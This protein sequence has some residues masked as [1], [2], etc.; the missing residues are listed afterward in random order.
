GALAWA[1]RDPEQRSLRIRLTVAGLLLWNHF[2]LYAE[3]CVHVSQAIEQLAAAGLCGTAAE[4]QLQVWLGSAPIFPRGVTLEARDAMRRALSIAVQINDIDGRSRCLRLIGI[5]EL[6][7]GENDAAIR[8]LETFAAL[9]AA[10]IPSAVL[11]AEVSLGI[12]EL[13][14]GRLRSVRRRFEARH[15]RNLQDVHDT[16]RGI[17]HVRYLSDRIVDVGDLLSHAQWLT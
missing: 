4:M 3:C 2:S 14:V 10:E 5:Y 9:A 13:F 6:F 15:A 1:G 12:G 17:Y 16:Q 7:A 8:T 11:E